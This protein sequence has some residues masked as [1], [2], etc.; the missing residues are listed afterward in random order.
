[1]VL[2]DK[3][4]FEPKI[5]KFIIEFHIYPNGKMYPQRIYP[6]GEQKKINKPKPSKRKIVDEE[7]VMNNVEEL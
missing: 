7:V 5:V 6:I 3:P 2:T 4:G 1:M